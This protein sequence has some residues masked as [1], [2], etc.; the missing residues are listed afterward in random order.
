LLANL[1]TEDLARGDVNETIALLQAIAN[2][3]LPEISKKT[4]KKI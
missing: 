1:I 4:R 3:S 2:C